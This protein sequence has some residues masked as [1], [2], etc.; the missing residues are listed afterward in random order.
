MR[1]ASDLLWAQAY[2]WCTDLTHSQTNNKDDWET[3]W[4]TKLNT[5]GQM[6]INDKLCIRLWKSTPALTHESGWR[7]SDVRSAQVTLWLW[8]PF[9]TQ[10]RIGNHKHLRKWMKLT[11]D[12]DIVI[13]P[14][15]KTL[16]QYKQIKL[17]KEKAPLFVVSRNMVIAI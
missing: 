4:W 7:Q 15:L 11:D 12:L 14:M 16:C 8:C 9:F 3:Y 17:F 1:V 2:I 5:A 10:Y 13:D 6:E